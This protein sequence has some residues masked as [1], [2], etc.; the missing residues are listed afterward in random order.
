MEGQSRAWVD[1]IEGREERPDRIL[2]AHRSHVRRHEKRVCGVELGDR[3]GMAAA[4]ESGPLGVR[5]VDRL[6]GAGRGVGWG[7]RLAAECG[8]E[9]RDAPD[10]SHDGSPLGEGEDDT[11]P[12]WLPQAAL[13]AVPFRSS[14]PVPLSV[15]ERGNGVCALSTGVE[16]GTFRFAGNASG[17]ADSVARTS[18]GAGAPSVALKDYSDRLRR[19]SGAVR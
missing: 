8:G 3:V 5:G 16:R 17:G 13:Y 1:R 11:G 15:P 18:S 12:A 2:A 9:R 6:L 7:G 14:P 4:R 10:G 19:S